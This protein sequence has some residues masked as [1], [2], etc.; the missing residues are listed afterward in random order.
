LAVQQN[1]DALIYCPRIFTDDDDELILIAIETRTNAMNYIDN[2]HKSFQ[3]LEIKARSNAM[4]LG[5]RYMYGTEP[6]TLYCV[7]G[8]SKQKSSTTDYKQ[9]KRW[10]RDDE[11]VKSDRIVSVVKKLNQHLW[12]SRSSSSKESDQCD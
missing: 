4:K 8:K 7:C 1:G 11:E 2:N 12:R 10:R 6:V 3:D 5:I 9:T